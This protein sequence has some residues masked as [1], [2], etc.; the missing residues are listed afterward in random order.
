MGLGT[1]REHFA[2]IAYKNH[3]HSVNNPKSQFQKE[4]TLDQVMNARKIYDFVGLLECRYTVFILLRFF[5]LS[6]TSDGAAAAILCSEKF[7]EKNP[8]LRAQAVEIVGMELGTDEP[9]VFAEKSNIK[10]IG[11]D[12]IKRI[13]ERLYKNTG[14]C[15][16]DVQVRLDNYF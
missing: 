4:Y 11:F 2:K 9:S 15:P 16:N 6:P 1:K 8:R 14:L 5:A 10:M 12:M 7:L 13:S 3:L